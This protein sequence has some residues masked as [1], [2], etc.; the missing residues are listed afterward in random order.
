MAPLAA[1]GKGVQWW[2]VSGGGGAGG[3]GCRQ[4]WPSGL[5]GCW[6]CLCP[7]PWGCP[8]GAAAALGS[9]GRRGPHGGALSPWLGSCCPWEGTARGARCC[10][11]TSRPPRPVDPQHDAAGALLAGLPEPPCSSSS[12]FCLQGERKEEKSRLELSL[13]LHTRLTELNVRSHLTQRGRGDKEPSVPL[14]AVAALTARA[15]GLRVGTCPALGAERGHG[16]CWGPCLVQLAQSWLQ[17]Q[18]LSSSS[19]HGNKEFSSPKV[20]LVV[21]RDGQGWA[22]GRDGQGWAAGR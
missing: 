22:A 10:R 2:G 5:G 4:Q 18:K 14:A 6:L 20:E 3:Q 17:P 1:G 21:G 19:S 12:S 16:R 7:Y 11:D 9:T 8:R 15:A 13:H